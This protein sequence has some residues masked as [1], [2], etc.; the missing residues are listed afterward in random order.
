ML[1][2]EPEHP[3]IG[4]H[5]LHDVDLSGGRSVV[6]NA[7]GFTTG[8]ASKARALLAATSP[9]NS[10]S[11]KS[12]LEQY[13]L[14]KQRQAAADGP[15]DDIEAKA[16]K[17]SRKAY[18][19]HLQSG[20]A[21]PVATSGPLLC[22]RATAATPNCRVGRGSSRRSHDRPSPSSPANAPCAGA[23]VTKTRCAGAEQ[24]PVPGGGTRP[25]TAP[26]RHRGRRGA[27]VWPHEALEAKGR[28]TCSAFYAQ[29]RRPLVINWRVFTTACALKMHNGETLTTTARSPNPPLSWTAKREELVATIAEA[30]AALF[31]AK[32]DVLWAFSTE[33]V[34]AAREK[35]AEVIVFGGCARGSQEALRAHDAIP[36]GDRS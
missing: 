22:I 10:S 13:K 17:R 4:E 30:G 7:P 6:P 18:R 27:V 12:L 33:G 5:P 9:P 1:R 21:A 28:R 31:S 24:K 36:E 32:G 26:E 3:S 14:W 8:R 11:A 23:C 25:T 20:I 2:P 35:T 29:H 34:K 19:K 15:L 16:L